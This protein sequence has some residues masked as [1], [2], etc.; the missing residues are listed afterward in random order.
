MKVDPK[1]THSLDEL[2]TRVLD[3]DIHKAYIIEVSQ[4]AKEP[5]SWHGAAMVALMIQQNRDLAPTIELHGKQV[6]V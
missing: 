3:E 6:E 2:T 4:L 5:G 1:R